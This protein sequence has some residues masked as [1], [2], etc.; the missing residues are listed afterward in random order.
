VRRHDLGNLDEKLFE[1]YAQR[2]QN[3]SSV[4][5]LNRSSAIAAGRIFFA[6]RKR[7]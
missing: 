4:H 1:F 5:E 6:R 7:I 2:I 3:V